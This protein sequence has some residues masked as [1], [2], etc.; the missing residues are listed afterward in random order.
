VIIEK[1]LFWK[2]MNIPWIKPYLERIN[3]QSSQLRK[4]VM[5]SNGSGNG[6]KI[7]EINWETKLE[8]K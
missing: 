3:E 2:F 1:S 8:W 7:E 4:Y 6:K 5:K